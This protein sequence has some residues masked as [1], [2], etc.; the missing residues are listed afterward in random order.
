MLL[1]KDL[2]YIL[3]FCGKG[4]TAKLTPQLVF[5]GVPL[6]QMSINTD[7]KLLQCILDYHEQCWSTGI[8]IG[9]MLRVE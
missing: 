5:N 7:L 3:W 9:S 2:F 6:A 4:D 8:D 1:I